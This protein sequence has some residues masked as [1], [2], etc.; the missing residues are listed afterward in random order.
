MSKENNTGENMLADSAGIHAYCARCRHQHVFVPSPVNHR[1]HLILSLF[2]LGLWLVSWAAVCIGN[3]LRPWRCERCGWHK[4]E[5]RMHRDFVE[6]SELECE[7]TE[8][9]VY[10]PYRTN[11]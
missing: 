11:I 8:P 1:F 4:P 2:T 9:G 6:K 10:V 5:F 7:Q 3:V